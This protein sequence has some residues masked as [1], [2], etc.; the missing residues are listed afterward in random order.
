MDERLL[1][2]SIPPLPPNVKERAFDALGKQPGSLTLMVKACVGP[3]GA[4][5]SIT[6]IKPSGAP[7][8]DE[9][10]KSAYRTYRYRPYMED[11]KPMSMCGTKQFVVNLQ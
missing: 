11:G 9:F 10:L 2:G 3:D 7:A 4:V 8:L 5:T 6:I 1:S